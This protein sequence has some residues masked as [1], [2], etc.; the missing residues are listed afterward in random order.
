LETKTV[1]NNFFTRDGGV[2]DKPEIPK[3]GF[4]GNQKSR[5]Q[6]T[7]D[8]PATMSSAGARDSAE[9][10]QGEEGDARERDA[11][12]KQWVVLCSEIENP[13]ITSLY[14]K[15]AFTDEKGVEEQKE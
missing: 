2:N 4:G 14:S 10:L 7:S 13:A 8:R 11:A 6:S 5:N 15:S 3:K 1:K 9:E 12:K